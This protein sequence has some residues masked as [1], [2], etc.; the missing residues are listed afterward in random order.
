MP[1]VNPS[2]DFGFKPGVT[3]K[4]YLDR[5]QKVF[6][7]ALAG[8]KLAPEKRGR[9]EI[10]FGETQ[11]AYIQDPEVNLLGRDVL[12]Q[13]LRVA[14]L[15]ERGASEERMSEERKQL[16]MTCG[17]LVDSLKPH[18]SQLPSR[19]EIAEAASRMAVEI[20]AMK[21][22]GLRQPDL[23]RAVTALLR[24]SEEGKARVGCVI[25]AGILAALALTG[26]IFVEGAVFGGKHVQRF[27]SKPEQIV[28]TDIKTFDYQRATALG[29]ELI[30]G[31]PNQMLNP[32]FDLWQYY[33]EVY[34]VDVLQQMKN[35]VQINPK[36]TKEEM[37]K[38][39]DKLLVN[40]KP[41]Y[42]EGYG[43]W[44]E[45]IWLPSQRP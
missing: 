43:W 23:T 12:R 9:L 10:L 39:I 41:K 42:T 26:V 11:Q 21:K 1:E 36:G 22:A 44:R 30:L 2:P 32:E 4:E 31:R 3:Q 27:T 45:N 17:K 6:Q 38:F 37:G 16:E 19:E 5:S 35:W 29:E 7:D 34:N 40:I 8:I 33:R 13:G 18:V 25:G 20:Q 24:G 14:R 15:G 28:E